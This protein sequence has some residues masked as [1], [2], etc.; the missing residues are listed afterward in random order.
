[1]F[2]HDSRVTIPEKIQ[3]Q[4]VTELGAY[5]FS[6]KMDAS[7][8]RRLLAEGCLFRE[9]AISPDA[10]AIAEDRVEEVILPE[11][12]EKVGRYAFYNCGK[13]RKI[14]FGSLLEDL[15]AGALT[16]CHKVE[17]LAVHTRENGQS[18]LRD[19]LTELPEELM[20]TLVREDAC[21]R[22]CIPEFFEEGV[23]NTPARILENHVHGSGIRYRNCFQHRVLNIR[24]YD[25]LFAYAVAWE[26]ENAV[27]SLALNRM[28]YPMELGEKA[29]K[30]YLEYLGEHME[31]DAVKAGGDRQ[32]AHERIRELS[33][34]AGR[35][36]KEEGKPN[37]LLELIAADPMFHLDAEKLEKSMDPKK[38]IGRAP[39][40]VEVYLRDIVQPRLQKYA[41]S[42]VEQ[43]DIEV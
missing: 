15:G 2:G 36:V 23:E 38:Y 27:I 41:G 26:N 8:A 7:D 14:S 24:E 1:M 29:K 42:V 4:A 20:V 13:L 11:T 18:C 31:K 32:E 10:P 9:K 21:G 12:L 25:E 28:L 5:L 34:Q 17:E 43:A 39:R 16:G 6:D 3:G 22:F 30:R 40:Q 35:R 37:N 33:M 19:F